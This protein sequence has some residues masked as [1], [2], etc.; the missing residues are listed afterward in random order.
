[1]QKCNSFREAVVKTEQD[2]LCKLFNEVCAFCLPS[3]GLT[4][5]NLF[6]LFNHCST[7]MFLW[8]ITLNRL[9][10]CK[11]SELSSSKSRNYLSIILN[12]NIFSHS[13]F[14]LFLPP[15]ADELGIEFMGKK[16][17]LSI[18]TIHL[19]KHMQPL[20]FMP[21]YHFSY[22]LFHKVFPFPHSGV[23]NQKVPRVCICIV[24]PPDFVKH[25][26]AVSCDYYVNG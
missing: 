5:T 6:L 8:L 12:K 9:L 21:I 17:I 24:L 4:G 10:C 20:S 14:S 1:M 25:H 19:T 22:R 3:P 23:T 11:C 18:I 26:S 7:E 2:F 16:K 13:H 15:A